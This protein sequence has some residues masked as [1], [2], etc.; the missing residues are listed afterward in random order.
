MYSVT[1]LRQFMD[2]LLAHSCDIAAQVLLV[3]AS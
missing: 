1:L 3:L 2:A